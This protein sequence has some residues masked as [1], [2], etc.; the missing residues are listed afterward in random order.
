[1]FVTKKDKEKKLNPKVNG[2]K[3]K[4]N[5]KKYAKSIYATM[6]VNITIELIIMFLVNL[7]LMLA[8]LLLVTVKVISF[9]LNMNKLINVLTSTNNITGPTKTNSVKLNK[10][11]EIFFFTCR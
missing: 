4:Y 10:I 1:M 11:C 5:W 6:K 7:E 3:V 8:F 9:F 2:S